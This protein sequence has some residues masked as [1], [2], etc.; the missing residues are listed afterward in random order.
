MKIDRVTLENFGI[1]T[2]KTL[3]LNSA[4]LVLIYGP[5][6]SGKTTALNGLRQALFGFKLRTPYLTSRPMSAE[7]VCRMSDGGLLEFSRRKGRGDD[8]TG[9]HNGRVVQSQDIQG[10]LCNLDLASYEHLFGFSL[11]ELREGEAALKS[12]RLTEALAGGGL[13]GM[14]VLQKLRSELQNSLGELY[15][16]RG[17][18]SKINVKLSDIKKCNDT[19]RA[20]QVLPAEVEDLQRA[21]LE[22]QEQSEQ[23][24]DK[25]A[26]AMR[27]QRAA[28]RLREAIPKFRQRAALVNQIEAM[29]VP[30][31]IDM[32]FVS[33]WGEYADQRKE[34]LETLAV[35][36]TT[37]DSELLQL[38]QLD[39]SQEISESESD[40][41]S[42]GHQAA[43]VSA[44]RS[45]LVDLEDEAVD[46]SAICERLLRTLEL[47]EFDTRIEKFSV[48]IP[49]R[50][51][52]E[53]LSKKYAE[54]VDESIAIAARLELSKETLL[55]NAH[56]PGAT[57]LPSNIVE[58]ESS[59]NKLL[60]FERELASKSQALMRLT[61]DGDFMAV[62]K[63]LL[64]ELGETPP[65]LDAEWSL[66]TTKQ[67]QQ[68]QHALEE[69]RREIAHTNRHARKLEKD[70]QVARDQLK[71][72]DDTS[73]E[74]ILSRSATFA[75]ARDTILSQWLDDLSQPLIAA[76]LTV[77]DQQERLIELQRLATA[78]DSIQDELLAAADALAVFNQKTQ[79]C[80]SVESELAQ[81]QRTLEKLSEDERSRQREWTELW[82]ALPS[83][84]P[85]VENA[86]DWLSDFARWR[87]TQRE[88]E[89]LR[90]EVYI[91]RGI[92]RNQRAALQDLWPTNLR[93]E[94]EV[95]ALA[96]QLRVW[97]NSVR[98]AERD[99]QRVTSAHQSV[100][101]LTQ[102]LEKLHNQQ[103]EIRTQYDAWLLTVPVSS[104]WPIEQVGNL[105]DT[106]E[107]LRREHATATKAELQAVEI[108][109]Q[110]EVFSKK[111]KVLSAQLRC[112]IS[113]GMPETHAERWLRELQNLRAQ[114]TT[115]IQ[116]SMSINH[117][118]KRVDEMEFKQKELD[119]KL[120]SLCTSSGSPDSSS[121]GTLVERVRRA[122]ELRLEIAELTA[123][124]E[125]FCGEESCA[126]FV[127]RL[128]ASNEGQIDFEIQELQ[129]ELGQL[130]E[131]R[132]QIDQ[133]IGSLTQR[134]EQ[135]ANNASAQ[136]SQQL[137]QDQRGE[138]AELSE[139][140]VI[141]RLAQELLSRSIDRFAAEHEPAL[142]HHTRDYLKKLTQGRYTSVEHDNARQGSFVVR[143]ARDESFT[144]DQ[145]STGAREQLY[146]AI[147]MAFITHHCE[148]HEPL[149]VIMDDCFVNFD[150][151]RTG[152]ALEAIANW[153]DSIQTVL[154]SC[155][156]RVVQ[157]L[158]EMA[159]GT[160][161]I[162][163]EK[164]L[165]TTAGELV[166]TS[167]VLSH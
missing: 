160:P 132:K 65:E 3:E 137:L 57:N 86:L 74:E 129:R 9:T 116:L 158:G 72:L 51:E 115:R 68:H 20:T 154:L 31:G 95:D 52:L 117:R 125:T 78:S 106:L 66:P 69:L 142:L 81:T 17:S 148:Y 76:S 37:L 103:N 62:R 163:L 123:S 165:Q 4:P 135:L 12:A 145:L 22:L 110:L 126:V 151:A 134:M 96:T 58:L 153:D 41:E 71:G 122:E 8:V 29:D 85:L 46:A 53:A 90:R 23:V 104:V 75:A 149:P 64:S 101:Q 79:L 147:R 112:D 143:N 7:V 11:D 61:E 28:Q 33:H 16:S 45:R 120:A 118:R 111:I 54:I 88:L 44:M 13:G 82:K 92:V 55:A 60:E 159:P 14:G 40:I 94:I 144:P 59:V 56:D 38:E 98:D 130:D 133:T 83:T 136:R 167:Q 127:K 124:I 99:R 48:G 73:A 32:A 139:Q 91:A 1:Y 105:I 100:L 166:A 146:L 24:R 70:F 35:E 18:N 164:E 34:L 114:R 84:V 49:K 108:R 141:Q 138:L 155:H 150:D 156:W 102:Q 107:Q 80:S 39:G 67:V 6:E 5:N 157:S 89:K 113:V 36:R 97:Q 109:Q 43:E 27:E 93:D 121:L 25:V 152:H 161:V 2:R 162:H 47:E 21:L 140:W 131:S 30:D 119:S 128:D 10:L 15:K 77:D 87:E 26:A 19:L 50:R 42:L 63:S